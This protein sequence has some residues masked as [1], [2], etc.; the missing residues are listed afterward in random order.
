MI[1]AGTDEDRIFN[2]LCQLIEDPDLRERMSSAKNPFG[3]GSAS[4]K[5][6]DIISRISS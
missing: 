1:S 3:D 5:I 4:A 6:A 2:A